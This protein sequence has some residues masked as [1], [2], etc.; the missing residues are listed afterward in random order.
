MAWYVA[1]SPFNSVLRGS[2]KEARLFFGVFMSA[3]EK[4]LSQEKQKQRGEDRKRKENVNTTVSLL[5]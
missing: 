2:L 3:T 4:K 1:Q 5:N